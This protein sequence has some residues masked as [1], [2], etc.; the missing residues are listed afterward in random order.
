[1]QNLLIAVGWVWAHGTQNG[2]G[3]TARLEGFVGDGLDARQ[4]GGGG[5]SVKARPPHG[6]GRLLAR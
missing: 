6:G 1:M 3:G 5:E 2:R 4:A